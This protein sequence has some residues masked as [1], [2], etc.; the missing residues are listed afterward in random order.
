M[1]FTSIKESGLKYLYKYTR[2]DSNSYYVNLFENILYFPNITQINDPFDSQIPIKYDLLND[3]QLEEYV[4]KSYP[5][6]DPKNLKHQII[7]QD[8]ISKIKHNPNLIESRLLDF[9]RNRTGI[10]SLAERKDNL[11]LWS[12]YA[13]NHSGLCF[14]FDAVKLN[15]LLINV[16]FWENV[17]AFIFKVIYQDDFPIIHPINDSVEERLQKQ[18]LMKSKA[19]EYEQ[20]WRILVLDGIRVNEIPSGVIKNVYLGLNVSEQN[21][22]IAKA[23][24]KEF[25]STVCLF[26]AKKAKDKFGL[27]FDQLNC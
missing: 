2:F 14:E 20:E 6:Y 17:K 26:K 23:L 7:I 13:S 10:F 19:W 1:V 24:I 16:F 3:E 15:E 12:H 11:L 18:F 5:T 4:K 27:E 21:V 8:A 9:T 25:N 22:K